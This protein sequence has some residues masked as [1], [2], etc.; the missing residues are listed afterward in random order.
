MKSGASLVILLVSACAFYDPPASLAPELQMSWWQRSVCRKRT[1]L[2]LVVGTQ[3]V[4]MNGGRD[5]SDVP[6]DASLTN[7]GPCALRIS[8]RPQAGHRVR[9]VMASAVRYRRSRCCV[10]GCGTGE[11]RSCT[12]ASLGDCRCLGV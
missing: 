7:D 4:I 3:P 5:V 10:C 8:A 9:D 1:K 11:K 6:W 2:C 12:S